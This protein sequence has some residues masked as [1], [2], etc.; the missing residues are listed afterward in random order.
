MFPG[1]TSQPTGCGSDHRELPGYRAS[2]PG[3][4]LDAA[5]REPVDSGDVT[6]ALI[7]RTHVA[8]KAAGMNAMRCPCGRARARHAAR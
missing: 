5:S 4:R 3:A 7:G 1:N 2:G 6:L 8:A